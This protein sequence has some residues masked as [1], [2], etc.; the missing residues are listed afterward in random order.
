MV[1]A[2]IVKSTFVEDLIVLDHV[3]RFRGVQDLST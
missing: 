3:V 1:Q 2:F